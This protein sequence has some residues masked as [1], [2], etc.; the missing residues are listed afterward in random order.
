MAFWLIAAGALAILAPEA[1]PTAGLTTDLL[2]PDSP[3]RRAQA[4][5]A[6]HFKSRSSLSE[7]VIVFARGDGRLTDQDRRAIEELA[8]RIRRPRPD[9]LRGDEL[10]KLTVRTPSQAAGLGKANPLVSPDGR[11]AMVYV[12]LPYSATSTPAARAVNHVHKVLGDRKLPPGLDAAVTGAA[13]F[14]RDYILAND[15]SHDKV[16][17]VTVIAVIVILLAVHRAPLAA[18]VPLAGIGLASLVAT[19]LMLLGH[20]VGLSSGTPERMFMLVLLF[21]AGVDY[22]VLFMSRYRDLVEKGSISGRA[23]ARG[24]DASL[25]AIIAAAAPTVAGLGLLRVPRFDGCREV[26]PAIVLALLVATLASLTFVPAMVRIIGPRLFWPARPDKAAGKPSRLVLLSRRRWAALSRFVT[27]R[28]ILVFVVT[29]A[30]LAA[31][32]VQSALL[33]W[34]YDSRSSLTGD[35]HAIRGTD[36]VAEHWPLD[37]LTPVVVLVVAEGEN[38]PDLPQWG[39]AFRRTA[40]AVEADPDV[41]GVRGLTRPLGSS[42]DERGRSAGLSRTFAW[43]MALPEYLSDDRQAMRLYVTLRGGPQTFESLD[44]SERIGSLAREAV[45]RA[46]IDA[47]VHLLGATAETAALR[48]VIREDF[49]RT[50][51]LAVIMIALVVVLL[52]R[53]PLLS[54]FMVAATLLCYAAT[55]GATYW[56]FSALG[57]PGLDW[58]VKVFLFLIMVAVG[59]D[60]N[61]FFAARLAQ[62]SRALPTDRRLATERALVH[63]GPVI[64]SCGLIMAATLGSLM[65]GDVKMLHQLGFALALGMLIDTFVVRPLLLPSFI[66][67]TRRSLARAAG[68]ISAIH[69]GT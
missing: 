45:R 3:F 28:P 36:M 6:E 43:I 21:G 69:D 16:Q 52:L 18:L 61:L 59:Q 39:D 54:A 17:V 40:S 10:D 68:I 7:A 11:A 2:P 37:A 44:A 38:P 22:S 9:G 42:P 30:V 49:R 67:L 57:V 34:S 66:L 24:L 35:Y 33:N 12:G 5:M 56:T 32:A 8:G 55:L 47:R 65:A 20:G 53:D 31:P 63:T 15:R 29:L 62:E 41:S 64:S 51:I 48:H 13:G 46:G 60:Y 50:A 19:R 25:G 58:E 4:A 23:A 1:D 14:G 27:H 26:E